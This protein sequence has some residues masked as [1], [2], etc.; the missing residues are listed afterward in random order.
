MPRKATG[1]LRA[2]SA[3][4]LAMWPRS[5]QASS[6]PR[7]TRPGEICIA[8][9]RGVGGARRLCTHEKHRPKQRDLR[10]TGRDFAPRL[11]L[12]VGHHWRPVSGSGAPGSPRT[13]SLGGGCDP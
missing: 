2:G 4:R 13:L 6:L 11:S 7:S 9:L 5:S 1:V 12:P 10:E 8:R 3:P